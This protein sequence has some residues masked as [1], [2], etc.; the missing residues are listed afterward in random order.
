VSSQE[1]HWVVGSPSGI[2]AAHLPLGSSLLYSLEVAARV[3]AAVGEG[4][5]NYPPLLLLLM[6][7]NRRHL[8][9]VLFCYLGQ[10]RKWL[11][12]AILNGWPSWFLH[13]RLMAPS[14]R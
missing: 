7:V 10:E 6:L 11:S 3:D 9:R 2:A 1:E 14:S 13:G 5:D 8:G 4:S 12:L